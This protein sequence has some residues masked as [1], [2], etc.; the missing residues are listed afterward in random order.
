MSNNNPLVSV[1]IVT[2]NRINVLK[3]CL[4]AIKNQ[5]FSKDL[6]EV[7]VVDDGSTDGTK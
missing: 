1:I 4:E 5:T 7:I 6:Y 3:N 2:Y